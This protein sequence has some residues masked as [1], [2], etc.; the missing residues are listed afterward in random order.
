MND[1]RNRTFMMITAVY[2]ASFLASLLF[3]S[4]AD[5]QIANIAMA[6]L[7]VSVMDACEGWL[8]KASQIALQLLA[9][10]AVIGFAIGMKDLVL[11][12]NLTMDGITALFVRYAFIVGILVW[13]LNAP[14][15]LATIPASIKKIGS[16]ISGQDISFGGL[17]D[18]FSDV[19]KPLV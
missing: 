3:V 18:L 9:I 11:A 6:E 13:L 7:Y 17:I 19:V 8:V 14:Q 1:A 15:R 5:A 16:T 2:L 10:T 4:R 12:G